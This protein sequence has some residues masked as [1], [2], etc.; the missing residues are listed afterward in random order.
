MGRQKPRAVLSLSQ[1]HKQFKQRVHIL[2]SA[3]S[4]Q[5]N[6]KA[7]N[8]NEINKESF[9]SSQTKNSITFTPNL[10]E[11]ILFPIFTS[12]HSQSH[13]TKTINLIR[14]HSKHNKKNMNK[15]KKK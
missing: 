8:H 13:A 5:N 12:I 6:I 10:M 1:N 2:N 9:I 11:C 15:E 3:L 7:K 14:K 4:N